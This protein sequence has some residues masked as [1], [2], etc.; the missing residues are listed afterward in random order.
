MLL[1]AQ[2]ILHPQAGHNSTAQHGIMQYSPSN[3]T[4]YTSASL[5]IAVQPNTAQHGIMQYSPSILQYSKYSLQHYTLSYAITLGV[6]SIRWTQYVP[7]QALTWP[8][9]LDTQQALDLTS[10]LRAGCQSSQ[11]N[12]LSN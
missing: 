5:H 9:W 6:G 1:A 8:D 10:N 11:A 2:P 7:V 4:L 12:P 3:K